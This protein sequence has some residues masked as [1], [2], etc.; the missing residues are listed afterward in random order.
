M[1]KGITIKREKT[2]YMLVSK[3]KNP[4]CVLRSGGVKTIEVQIFP[5]IISILIGVGNMTQ[6]IRKSTRIAKDAFI[7]INKE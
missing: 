7:N 2:E 1:K 5:S 6:G 3:R 4:R